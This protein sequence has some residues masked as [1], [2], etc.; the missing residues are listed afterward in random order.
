MMKKVI[1]VSVSSF[2]IGAF[3]GF[4][5]D[6]PQFSKQDFELF[7]SFSSSGKN[8]HDTVLKV[9]IYRDNNIQELFDEIRDFHTTMNGMSDE[10]TI[11]LYKSKE[12]LLNGNAVAE[13]TFHSE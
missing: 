8:Y 2:L 7:Q 9:I 4:Y 12:D 5:S 13:M 11:Q 1:L 3:I 6:M 10:L